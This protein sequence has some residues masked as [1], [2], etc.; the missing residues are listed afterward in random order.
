MKQLLRVY[1]VSLTKY[2][3]TSSYYI[4]SGNFNLL[5]GAKRSPCMPRSRLRNFFFNEKSRSRKNIPS[6]ILN[7][8]FDLAETTKISIKVYN[9]LLQPLFSSNFLVYNGFPKILNRGGI[10][11][12]LSFLRK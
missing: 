1:R 2:K 9:Y 3:R 6:Y 12:T 11:I 10:L 8:R 5:S 7:N 4:P